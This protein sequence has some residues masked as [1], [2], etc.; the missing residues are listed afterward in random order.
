[1]ARRMSGRGAG[2]QLPVVHFHGGADVPRG[3]DHAVFSERWFRGDQPGQL[4]LLAWQATADRRCRGSATALGSSAAFCIL[5]SYPYLKRVWH[6]SATELPVAVP[7][8][9]FWAKLL[10]FAAWIWMSNLLS[11]VFDMIDRYMIVHFSGLEVNEALRQ[12]GYYHTS[13]LLPLLFVA[14]S[15]LLGSMITPHLSH[16][17][18][19]GRRREVGAR[20]N[21]VLKAL[22]LSLFAASVVVLICAPFLFNTVLGGKFSGGLVQLPLTLVYCTWFGTIAV[23]QNYLWCAEKA[24]LSSVAL[25]VGLVV[26]VSLDLALLPRV[27]LHGAVMATTAAN[28]PRPCLGSFIYSITDWE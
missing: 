6:A 5:G 11:G 2:L 15:A 25:F 23:A 3:D 21:T 20:L 10:P 1:M 8:R 9:T 27:G 13:R 14:V 17:W 19:L 12:V 16:D 26:N 22:D 18:E 4:V 28:F 7:Q 24:W